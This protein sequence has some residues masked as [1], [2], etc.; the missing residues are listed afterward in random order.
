[1]KLLEDA[2][3]VLMRNAG[4]GIGHSD[5]KVAIAGGGGDARL[6]AGVR[7]WPKLT[8]KLRTTQP[9]APDQHRHRTECDH[10]CR[11]APEQ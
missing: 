2:R 6:G 10:L 1:M 11:L 4:P 5:G 8:L 9:L 7:T 3:L